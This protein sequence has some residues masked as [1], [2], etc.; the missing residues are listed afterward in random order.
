MG[1]GGP[2]LGLAITRLHHAITAATDDA[3]PACQVLSQV[4]PE[5]VAIFA[6]P[7]NTAV[8][9]VT[10]VRLKEGAP[11]ATITFDPEYSGMKMYPAVPIG[12]M[13]EHSNGVG[14]LD[15]VAFPKTQLLPHIEWIVSEAKRL[16]P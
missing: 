2:A 16:F 1:M 15:V 8:T 12:V 3:L 13:V 4:D 9:Y 10:P 7:P 5:I 6:N 14:W 11:F